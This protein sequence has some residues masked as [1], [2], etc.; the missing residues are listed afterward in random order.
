MR[1]R[2][3]P[4]YALAAT[5]VL[6][7]STT[8]GAQDSPAGQD[9]D[10]LPAGHP[11]VDDSANPHA[12]SNGSGAMPGV[13][14]PPDDTVHEDPSLAPGTIEVELRDADD[15]PVPHEL[16]TLGVLINSIAKGDSRKHVQLPT[17]ERGRVAFSGLE[18]ASN[19]AYRV[20]AGFQGGAFAATPFQ[21]PQG[22]AERVVLHVYPVSRDISGALVVTEAT[23]AAE[24]R[25]DRI[26]IEEALT[27]Y[28]LGKT[29]WQPDDVRL[30][31]P[32]GFTAF[33]AQTTMSDQGVDS[34]DGGGKLRGTFPPGQHPVEFRWQLPWSGDS[35]VDF[36]VGLPPHT[37]IVR[38]MLPVSAGV[39]LIAGGFPPADVRRDSRGQSFLVTERRVRPDDARLSS[40]SIGLHGLPT[41]GP[42][43]KIATALAALA[44]AAG[45]FFAL[46]RRGAPTDGEGQQPILDELLALEQARARGDVGPH[47]Y[48][49]ARRQ[50]IDALAL[51]LARG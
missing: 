36:D 33:G 14:Q 24:L 30:A 42:G 50:L 3:G 27:I 35:D 10:E 5:F 47:T 7:L 13:F 41:P 1:R 23:V 18:M 21:L 9:D 8:A 48:E 51:V 29:A 2:S 45:L 25:D 15:R 31:L 44:V 26:Q 4:L 39:K 19:I 38:V 37:A 32:T 6:A 28:N 40:I 49:K 11:A 34:T 22:K 20:S 17:D 46:A 43:R 12:A 16:V